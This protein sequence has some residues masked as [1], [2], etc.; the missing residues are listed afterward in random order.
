MSPPRSAWLAGAALI[1]LVLLVTL[2]GLSQVAN[3]GRSNALV[4]KGAKRKPARLWEAKARMRLRHAHVLCARTVARPAEQVVRTRLN[5][6]IKVLDLNRLT[7][8]I[9]IRYICKNH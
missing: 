7:T 6:Q 9:F 5:R 8:K 3:G 4:D 1:L 2:G